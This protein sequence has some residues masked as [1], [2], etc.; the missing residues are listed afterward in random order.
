M[1]QNECM[2]QINA[3]DLHGMTAD[4][5]KE[6]LDEH[7]EI[8]MLFF[9]TKIG[10]IEKPGD[11]QP[12]GSISLPELCRKSKRLLQYELRS[13]KGDR[14]QVLSGQHNKEVVAHIYSHRHES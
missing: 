11:C 9:N 3:L 14:M 10:V 6:L 12:V 13:L 5:F 4:K 1:V 2:K 7:Q 8:E